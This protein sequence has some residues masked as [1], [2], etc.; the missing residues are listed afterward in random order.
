MNILVFV[1]QIPEISK[2]QFD[3]ATNRIKRDQVPL[4]INPFDKRAVEEGIRQKEKHGG[5][6]TVVTMGP[7]FASDVLNSSLRMGADRAILISDPLFAGADTLVTAKVLSAVVR[8]LKPEIV[9]LGKY[10]LDGE[11]SQ[12]PPEVAVMAGYPFKTSVSKIEF[13]DERVANVEQELESGFA[14][15]RMEVPFLLSVSEKINRARFVNPS[16]PDMS[17]RIERWSAQDTGASVRGSDSPTVVESTERIESFRKVKMLSSTKEVAEIIEGIEMNETKGMQDMFG[18]VPAPGLREH[19]V[20]VSFHDRKTAMEIS[21][22]MSDLGLKNSFSVVVIGN[23]DP[24]EIE[25]IRC[26]KYIMLNGSSVKGFSEYL[27]KYIREK[28]PK[29]VVFSSTI[30]GR[31]ISSYVA[32]SLSLGLTADCIDLDIQ[33]GKLVQFK[34]AFGGGMVARIT[35]KTMPAMASVRQGIFQLTKS[36]H[37]FS[38]EEV[39]LNSSW[40]ETALTS[41]SVPHDF[42]PLSDARVVLGI[43]KGLG[44]KENVSKVLELAG[45]L[46]ASVGGTRP[47]VDLNWIP[48]QQQ[49]G[50]TGFS[51]SPKLYIALGISGHDNHVVGIR[52]AGTVIAVNKDPGAPIFRYADFGYVGDAEQFVDELMGLLRAS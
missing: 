32:A 39:D 34:P 45:K 14:T 6:V 19:A 30:S 22:K 43:G 52:Y 16:V 47:I 42:V 25:G 26:S 3:P 35:S 18:D 12:I 50:L 10:S 15:Y 37:E 28:H 33:D 17:S 8:K 38:I 31:E 4:I 23:N 7:P 44:R 46:K 24:E 48:R 5:Q 21:G 20:V 49:V 13:I 2:I 51:I 1:K 11:T 9:L 27:V 40:P 41:E 29:Y 36:R